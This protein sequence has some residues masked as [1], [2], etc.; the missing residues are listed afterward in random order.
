MQVDTEMNRQN[1]KLVLEKVSTVARESST[2]A[3]LEE[4]KESIM[5]LIKLGTR[6]ALTDISD[7]HLPAVLQMIDQFSKSP[8]EIELPDESCA[9]CG[10][11][12]CDCDWGYNDYAEEYNDYVKEFGEEDFN[13]LVNLKS[14]ED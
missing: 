1:I 13:K 2:A 3:N 6:K 9:Y 4:T 11:D 5:T 14:D 12:P 10:C 7:Y 8:A